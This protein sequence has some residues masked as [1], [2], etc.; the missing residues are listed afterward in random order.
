MDVLSIV[1]GIG[2]IVLLGFQWFAL[3]WAP[4]GETMGLRSAEWAQRFLV[5]VFFLHPVW[6]IFCILNYILS[7]FLGM[8]RYVWIVA[9]FVTI[10]LAFLI[11]AFAPLLTFLDKKDT[12]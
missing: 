7:N 1:G 10:A 9:S 8:N 3:M 5:G 4:I 2:L 12:D 6:G 11:F